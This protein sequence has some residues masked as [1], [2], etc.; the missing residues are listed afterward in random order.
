M[1]G[2]CTNVFEGH[3]DAVRCI[4]MCN[5]VIASGSYDH[6][7]RL[8]KTSATESI[9]VLHGHDDKIY[10]IRMTEAWIASG[11]LDTT[12]RVWSIATGE[13]TTSSASFR[14]AH[15]ISPLP[16]HPPRVL[17]MTFGKRKSTVRGGI[18]LLRARGGPLDSALI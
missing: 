9:H 4:D 5:E 13:V 1:V 18:L 14:R 2:E 6:S 7:I 8:W 17:L 11:S 3:G 16:A 12:I 10:S 15:M